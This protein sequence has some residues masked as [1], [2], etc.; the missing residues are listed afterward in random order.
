MSNL[1]PYRTAAQKAEARRTAR[2]DADGAWR[3]DA[4]FSIHGSPGEWF[5]DATHKVPVREPGGRQ[6]RAKPAADE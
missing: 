2:K 6:K 3:S 5:W 1:K 4:P